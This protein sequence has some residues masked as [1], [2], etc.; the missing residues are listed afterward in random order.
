MSL[1]DNALVRALAESKLRW[2]TFA[3]VVSALAFSA[4]YFIGVH[5]QLREN[6]RLFTRAYM[7]NMGALLVQGKRATNEYSDLIARVQA[8]RIPYIIVDGQNKPVDWH[9]ITY[10]R[11]FIL[12]GPEIERTDHSSRAWNTLQARI[13][14]FQAEYDPVS[15]PKVRALRGGPYKIYYGEPRYLGFM[16]LFPLFQVFLLL[17]FGATLYFWIVNRELNRQ[18]NLW[19]GFAKETAH[20]LG[21]PISSLIGWVEMLKMKLGEG[22]VGAEGEALAD[23][24]GEIEED[25]GKLSK[26]TS[27]FAQIGSV[28]DLMRNDVNDMVRE[29]VAYFKDRLPQGDRRIEIVSNYGILPKVLMNRELIGW[30]LENLL[31][32]SLDAIVKKEGVIEIETAWLEKENKVRITH[33]DNGKGIKREFLNKIFEP[34]F[35]TKRRGWGLGLALARRIVTEYHFGKIT[36]DS[37][38]L[39][40]GTTFVIELP[41]KDAEA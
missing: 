40:R 33:T 14:A 38:Q 18:S 2:L 20:Q 4:A 15:I 12:P 3:A 13:R 34:G 1:K 8:V 22:A 9:Y 41:V 7:E 39:D 24:V 17:A 19:V 36:V 6:T 29:V 32:N 30:V 11:L 25:I 31:K 23:L 10:P 37:T 28:P 16:F 21:T 5:A 27:R 26:N 35:S